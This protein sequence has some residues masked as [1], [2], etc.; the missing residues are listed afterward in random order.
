MRQVVLEIDKYFG[1]NLK[2]Y[3]DKYF[4][5]TEVVV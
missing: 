1:I 3:K 4:E 5:T 2:L